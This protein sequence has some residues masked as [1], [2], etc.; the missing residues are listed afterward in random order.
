MNGSLLLKHGASENRSAAQGGVE[1]IERYCGKEKN[2]GQTDARIPRGPLGR[3]RKVIQDIP[4]DEI[5]HESQQAEANHEKRKQTI[6]DKAT[7]QDIGSK[8]VASCGENR[9][10][11]NPRD[12][13]R[14]LLAQQGPEK[15][16]EKQSRQPGHRRKHQHRGYISNY[17][18]R[19]QKHP[20]RARRWLRRRIAEPGENKPP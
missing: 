5:S 1:G 3:Q 13:C 20:F 9:K 10:Y 7:Q 8:L 16:E 18:S 17:R 15:D 19:A 2:P 12:R 14:P 4:E 11:E 6:K